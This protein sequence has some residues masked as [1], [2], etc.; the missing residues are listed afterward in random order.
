MSELEDKLPTLLPLSQ[1]LILSYTRFLR[2]VRPSSYLGQTQS[3]AGNSNLYIRFGDPKSEVAATM[4]CFKG[5]TLCYSAFDWILG[6]TNLA[7]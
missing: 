3:L 7:Q 6:L 4:Y 5:S 2:E 1:Q